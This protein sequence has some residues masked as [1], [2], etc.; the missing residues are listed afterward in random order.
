MNLSDFERLVCKMYIARFIS[1]IP[2]LYYQFNTVK[3]LIIAIYMFPQILD[4]P[5]NNG[6]IR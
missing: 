1:V 6:I 5:L 2:F 4:S 3:Q